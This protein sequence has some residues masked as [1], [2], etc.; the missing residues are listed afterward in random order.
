MT[1]VHIP[2]SAAGLAGI[3]MIRDA[4]IAR[5]ETPDTSLETRR[6]SLAA[7]AA[8]SPHVPGVTIEEDRLGDVRSL[9]IAPDGA[10]GD[11]L[12]LHGGAYVLGSADT[13]AG[14][15]ARYA[16]AGQCTFHA[17]DYRLAPEHPY[18]AAVEDAVAAWRDLG[19]RGEP[20]ALCGDSAGGGLAL[21]T[22]LHIRDL[23][24]A[25]PRLIALISPWIDLTLSSGS[26]VTR[27]SADPMLT[28][29]GLEIDARRY[30]GDRSVADPEVSPLFADLRSLP[31]LFVQVGGDEVLLDD[32]LGLARRIGPDVQMDVEVWAGMTHAWAA[33]GDAVPQ[34]SESI[35]SV[36]QRL[37]DARQ[38][39]T[40]PESGHS[41][42]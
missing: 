5:G 17:L 26:M 11:V 35:A 25:P 20:L 12:Y 30:A 41:I 10:G 21:A 15:A 31:P 1:V 27:A 42:S 18:P 14:L 39:A 40:L 37:K 4:I 9:R 19:K 34:A 24:L 2:A 13:H 29:D 33:F 32:T 36:G 8:A 22:A 28:R 38:C 16:V 3:A 23:D 6:N 7:F